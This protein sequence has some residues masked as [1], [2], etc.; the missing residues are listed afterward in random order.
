MGAGVRGFLLPAM[1]EFPQLKTIEEY[2]VLL[3]NDQLRETWFNTQRA[4]QDPITETPIQLDSAESTGNSA[5]PSFQTILTVFGTHD[6]SLWDASVTKNRERQALKTTN[7]SGER[8][9]SKDTKHT[10]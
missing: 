9:H 4:S 5:M 1:E 8:L 6:Q 7:R 10:I 3:S 2:K